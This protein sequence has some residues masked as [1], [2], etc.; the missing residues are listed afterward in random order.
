MTRSRARY[1]NWYIIIY[2]QGEYDPQKKIDFYNY[3]N[4]VYELKSYIIAQE[5]YPNGDKTALDPDKI[6]DSHLQANL[7]FKNQ[8]DFQPFLKY[9][10]KRYVE[11]QSF[12]GLM[13]RTQLIP[14]EKREGKSVTA[15][16]NYL[17]G[18]HKLGA[19]PDPLSDMELQ[20]KT[21]QDAKFHQEFN[22]VL[23]LAI[24]QEVNRRNFKL[25]ELRLAQ[26]FEK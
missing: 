17:S 5:L 9:L 14:I 19:D 25:D 4:Q 16:D 13:C 6:G 12:K 26:F 15:I 23:G 3:V 11:Q 7:Y 18:S 24:Q 8:V 2:N 22:R 20:S 1:R 21:R 10:Q